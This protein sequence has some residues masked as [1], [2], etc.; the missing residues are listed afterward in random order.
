MNIKYILTNSEL[1]RPSGFAQFS[2]NSSRYLTGS[3]K[4]FRFSLRLNL[5]HSE[6]FP[7][8]YT[9]TPILLLNKSSTL[10]CVTP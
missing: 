7:T 4:R 5:N 2:Q 6:T 3:P 9:H 1:F 10:K 8:C